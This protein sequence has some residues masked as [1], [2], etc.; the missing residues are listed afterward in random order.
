[1]EKKK[2]NEITVDLTENL[3]QRRA[4]LSRLMSMRYLYIDGIFKDPLAD[5]ERKVPHNKKAED[6]FDGKS[7]ISAF[8]NKTNK[9]SG[10]HF[11]RHCKPCDFKQ[12]AN[13]TDHKKKVHGG[14]EVLFEKCL[15]W[16]I[17]CKSK[18]DKFDGK[19]LARAGKALACA[20]LSG[21]SASLR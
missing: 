19:S 6:I 15:S 16:C 7:E 5:E 14:V 9:T 13:W 8:T 2:L 20:S 12:I 21:Q 18:L 1:M 17:R 11:K 4:F 3:T 10:R